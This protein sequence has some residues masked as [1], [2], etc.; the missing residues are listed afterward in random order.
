[1][2]PIRVLVVDDVPEVLTVYRRLFAR[3]GMD[4]H[5]AENGLRA[6][7]AIRHEPPAVVVT[8]IDMP[9]MN[10]HELC[11]ALRADPVLSAIPI[12]VLS[13]G[14][15]DPSLSASC[16]AVLEK[17]CSADVLVAAVLGAVGTTWP[18]A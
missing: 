3:A 1:M 13:G 10:G 6:L 17:P 11:R 9:L 15:H 5:T 8:D 14:G 16:H 7:E 12:V 18:V 2:R 4:V